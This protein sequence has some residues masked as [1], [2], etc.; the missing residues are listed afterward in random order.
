MLDLSPTDRVLVFPSGDG[1]LCRE[2]AARVPLGL[3]VG[4]DPSDENV[5]T[6]R[7]AARDIDNIMFVCADLSEIPWN[8]H[9]FSVA[10]I[11]EST[12]DRKEVERVMAEGGRVVAILGGSLH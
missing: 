10:L 6:A 5:R 9:F 7:V 3:V 1:T 11:P 4:L 8:A 2:L 12:T